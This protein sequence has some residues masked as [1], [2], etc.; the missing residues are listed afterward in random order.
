MTAKVGSVVFSTNFCF[1]EEYISLLF[2]CEVVLRQ[3][4]TKWPR[5]NEGQIDEGLR[6]RNI[7]QSIVND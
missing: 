4:R 6:G 3:Q 5:L 2:S 7:K 1:S